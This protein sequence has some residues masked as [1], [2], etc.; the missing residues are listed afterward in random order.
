MFHPSDRVLVAILKSRRDFQIARDEGWYRIPQRT[1]P[2]STTEALVL[3]FYFPRVFEEEKW[4]IHWY[5]PIR[6]HELVRRRHLLPDEPDHPRAGDPYYKLQLGPLIRLE[7]PIRSLRWRRI[8]FIET[9]WDRFVAAE[10]INDLY[11]SAADGLFVTLKEAG[12]WPEREFEVREEGA[13]YVVDLASPCR[14]GVVAIDV[15]GRA[16]P[17]GAL[18]R[19]DLGRVRRV[20]RDLGGEQPDPLE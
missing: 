15:T 1:A 16:T 19:P 13:E 2:L 18:H 12:F 7:H 11:S 20:V 6:G 3:A 14:D 9:S 5:A 8:T 10:E 4:A 17:P